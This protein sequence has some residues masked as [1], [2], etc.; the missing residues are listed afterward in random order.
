MAVLLPFQG[1]RYNPNK[2]KDLRKVVCPPYDVINPQAQARYY[3]AHEHNMIRLELGKDQPDDTPS[4]NRYTRAAAFFKDWIKQGVLRQDPEPSL[5]LYKLDY[6][7]PGK[8]KKTLK[9]VFGLVQLEEIGKGKIFPHEFTFPKAKEDRLRLMRVCHA[10]TSPIFMIYS[11]PAGEIMGRL[12][13]S[14]DEAR[15]LVNF[16]GE[17][18]I[19]HRLWRISSPTV[20][21]A[22]SESLKEQPFFIADG[23][24][25][26][27]TALNF[28]NEMRE[29]DR[30]PGLKPYDAVFVFCADMEDT[31]ISLLPIHRVI[32]NPVPCDLKTLKQRLTL[33]FDVTHLE[34]NNATESQA[35]KKLFLEMQK[36]GRS[37]VV[38]GMFA[39]SEQAFHLLKLKPAPTPPAPKTLDALDVSVFQKIIL[40]EAMGI[41][42]PAAKKESLIQFVKDEEAAV[43]MVQNGSAGMTFFLNPTR[44]IQVRDVVLA[45]DRMPQKSTYFYPKPLTGLVINKF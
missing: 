34:F 31:G 4:S 6:A 42:D 28:R 21:T 33:A 18:E 1:L 35:R 39:K 41:A 17:E 10:N 25:R 27:E 36:E 16:V 5:Y 26:Y 40:E 37:A 44:I 24:H 30:S 2:V 3:H 23:H 15:P 29:R 19:R 7:L 38:F 8:E 9:G 45:G 20:T 22:V 14:V 13:R 43:K 32:M 11:D 12:E